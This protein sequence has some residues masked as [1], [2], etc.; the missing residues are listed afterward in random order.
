MNEP[1]QQKQQ[2]TLILQQFVTHILCPAYSSTQPI[3]IT[4]P[5]NQLNILNRWCSAIQSLVNSLPPNDESRENLKQIFVGAN[6]N[7]I[8]TELMQWFALDFVQEEKV[9]L[10]VAILLNSAHQHSAASLHQQMTGITDC[11][12]VLEQATARSVRCQLK[13]NSQ[14]ISRLDL[15]LEYEDCINR[16][17]LGCWLK[18]NQYLLLTQDILAQ[19]YAI[20]TLIMALLLNKL[21]LLFPAASLE[22]LHSLSLFCNNF[23]KKYIIFLAKQQESEGEQSSKVSKALH[24]F[25]NCC[26]SFYQFELPAMIDKQPTQAD[27]QHFAAKLIQHRAHR[28]QDKVAEQKAATETEAI[29]VALDELIVPE[30]MATNDDW[31]LP[32]VDR[33]TPPFDEEKLKLETSATLEESEPFVKQEKELDQSNFSELVI[34]KEQ[35]FQLDKESNI[36][37]ASQSLPVKSEQQISL[38]EEEEEFVSPLSMPSN[39]GRFCENL[40][41]DW[42]AGGEVYITASSAQK[43]I[44][45][46]QAANSAGEFSG[47]ENPCGIN[48]EECVT[49]AHRKNSIQEC[50]SYSNGSQVSAN[51]KQ[52]CGEQNNNAMIKEA[53]AAELI[54]EQ[55]LLPALLCEGSPVQSI[56]SESF[57]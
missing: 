55:S 12:H 5:S 45:L 46:K 13:A 10:A 37:S 11:S 54:K 30:A 53:Q 15:Y 33:N 36:Q 49:H 31:L 32:K 28:A 29:I 44:R 9:E 51:N 47:S 6:R 41:K 18:S 57:E 40:N 27:L 34:K 8:P 20:S 1:Q 56:E 3:N 48:D 35:P 17:L 19:E 52:S 50:V 26:G 2:A 21:A 23:A 7:I 24:K 22:L 4:I 38:W 43:R 39:K 16:I 42:T 14:L 25:L